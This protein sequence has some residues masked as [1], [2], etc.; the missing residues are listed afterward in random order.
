[1]SS[2]LRRKF[3][4]I[5]GYKP[6]NENKPFVEGNVADYFNSIFDEAKTLQ[7]RYFFIMMNKK[8]K[9]CF[10]TRGSLK[11]AWAS[12]EKLEEGK[13]YTLLIAWDT[14]RSREEILPK[15][16]KLK[17]GYQLFDNPIN[18]MDR[19]P[20]QPSAKILQFKKA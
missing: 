9:L 8:G 19:N 7:K 6:D 5:R 13:R 11:E 1:M 2:E 16:R 14:F 10:S 4:V 20:N 17:T 18:V 3:K 15:P 12:L